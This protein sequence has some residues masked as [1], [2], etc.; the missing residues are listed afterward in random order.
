MAEQRLRL[1]EIV[2][3]ATDAEVEAINDRVGDAICA[4]AEH[5]GPCLTPWTTMLTDV[6]DL[7][8]PRRS[9]LRALAED[10]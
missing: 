8:E 10:P 2:V 4:P 5:E 1:I 7:D 9:E 6:D 3:R